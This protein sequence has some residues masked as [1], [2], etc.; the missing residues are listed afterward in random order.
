[1]FS[2]AL[3][4]TCAW[5]WRSALQAHFQPL[6]L[7]GIHCAIPLSPVVVA[8]GTDAKLMTK[9]LDL[10]PRMGLVGIDTILSPGESLLLD[11]RLLREK[12]QKTPI[13]S[14]SSFGENGHDGQ[15]C[16]GRFRR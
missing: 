15:G 7:K 10:H 4:H 6:E 12:S 14:V 2:G 8:R 16:V 1:M 3:P 5:G 9:L 11:G 13:T